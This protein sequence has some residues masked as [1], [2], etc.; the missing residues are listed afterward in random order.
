MLVCC[1]FFCQQSSVEGQKTMEEYKQMKGIKEC[2]DSCNHSLIVSEEFVLSNYSEIISYHLFKIESAIDSDN[3]EKIFHHVE[4]ILFTYFGIDINIQTLDEVTNSL[5]QISKKSKHYLKVLNYVIYI[6]G[7]VGYYNK[8]FK[9]LSE[10][11]TEI[12]KQDR[13][14]INDFHS[15]V[16]LNYYNL[17]LHDFAY[18]EIDQNF[19]N[20]LFRELLLDVKKCIKNNDFTNLTYVFLSLDFLLKDSYGTNKATALLNELKADCLFE[21]LKIEDI[22]R[23]AKAENIEYKY[24]VY[25]EQNFRYSKMIADLIRQKNELAF[26]NEVILR[27]FTQILK[28]NKINITNNHYF[29]QLL[30]IL[31]ESNLKTLDK[32][33]LKI[34]I[35]TLDESIKLLTF[36][37]S[38]R[39]LP[40]VVNY[41]NSLSDYKNSTHYSNVLNKIYEKEFERRNSLEVAYT[42]E[43]ATELKNKEEDLQVFKQRYLVIVIISILLLVIIIYSFMFYRFKLKSQ[44]KLSFLNN[45]LLNKNVTIRKH[46]KVLQNF[47]FT[48][49]H[50][51]QE[52]LRNLR[53]ALNYEVINSMPVRVIGEIKEMNDASLNYLNNLISDFLSY[54]LTSQEKSKLEK[55]NIL[56]CLELAKYN[57]QY[58]AEEIVLHHNVKD[59]YVECN[60]SEIVSIFQN[61][62]KNSI[63]YCA[64]GKIPEIDVTVQYLK[65]ELFIAISDNGIGIPI[66]KREEIF[67]PFKRLSNV[68]KTK[69]SGLGLSIVS[70]IVKKYNGNIQVLSNEKGGTLIEISLKV[71]QVSTQ[72]VL[73]HE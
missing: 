52:P 66:E 5:V 65:G 12:K 35:S 36:N 51:F 16:Y 60:Q 7:K 24:I 23:K 9:Y 29:F 42:F 47:A 6:Y 25:I 38:T 30:N 49:A 64:W 46:N 28:Q 72:K 61:L 18:K 53:Y 54:C 67:L 8:C 69:G 27:D 10:G 21:E 57:V 32:N 50:D 15:K 68:R 11:L 19:E 1:L 2:S 62:L 43:Q 63:K 34:V 26:G 59:L 44:Q 31:F 71:K 37:E 73:I 4:L 48:L 39:L 3:E 20:E 40:K 70:N 56:D 14:L 22:L 33:E 55:V 17:Y 41:F 13:E 58:L 45:D